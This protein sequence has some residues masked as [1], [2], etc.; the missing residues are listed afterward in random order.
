MNMSSLFFYQ[1]HD[2]DMGHN[3]D[4]VPYTYPFTMHTHNTT[5]ILYLL[6]GRGTLHVEGSTYNIEPG[7]LFIAAPLEA[8]YI[9]LDCSVPYERMVLH[10]YTDFFQDMDIGSYLL[11][12]FLQRKMGKNNLY[13]SHLFK[14]GCQP[15]WDIIM[16]PIGNTRANLISGL[17]P[18]LNELY[19]IS[20]TLERDS[21]SSADTLEY[22]ILRYINNNL[23]SQISL[24][25]ICSEYYISKPHLCRLFKKATGSTVW[26]YIT[27]KRLMIAKELLL[28]GEKPTAVH[29]Q[30]GFHDYSSF[31]RAY[32]KQFG[33]SPCEET[34]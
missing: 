8:H 12:P 3:L 34:K 31:Y 26:H 11:A 22:R 4:T 27:V 15:Y 19:H 2:F 9:E 10:F 29:A 7:D 25:A 24:D 17:L 14:A 5:E 28:K 21:D 6:K 20:I 32:L 23:S 30:C 13:K 1:D 18:L 16:S 33:C